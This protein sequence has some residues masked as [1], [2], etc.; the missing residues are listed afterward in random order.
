MDKPAKRAVP[1]NRYLAFTTIALIGCGL[2]LA[3]KAWVF[4]WLGAPGGQTHWIWRPYFGLQTSLNQGAL[5]GMGQGKVW[6]FAILSLAAGIGIVYW[7]FVTGAAVDRL[8]TV[9]L[10]AVMAGILGNLYDRLGLWTLPGNPGQ[11][12]HAVR[13]WILVQYPPWTWPNFNVADSSLV[14][15]AALLMWHAFRS[16]PKQEV[17]AGMQAEQR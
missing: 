6:L 8:L 7:L 16:N 11:S 4:A 12:I 14:C 13:D 5:F 2:D 1:A 3:T 9:A 17:A 15:G 10:G